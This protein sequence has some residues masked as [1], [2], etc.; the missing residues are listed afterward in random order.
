[1]TELLGQP[2]DP[3]GYLVVVDLVE[4]DGAAGRDLDKVA[5]M[6]EATGR[7][8]AFMETIRRVGVV[9]EAPDRGAAMNCGTAAVAAAADDSMAVRTAEVRM[10][11][12]GAMQAD[13]ARPG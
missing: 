4:R 8:L 1:M 10:M 5:A 2:P 11:P 13:P 9:V 3:R 6:L 7:T 12:A